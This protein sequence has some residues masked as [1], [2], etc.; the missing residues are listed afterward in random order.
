MF[1]VS[2]DEGRT[3]SEGVHVDPRFAIVRNGC[4]LVL[5]DG[6]I[7]GPAYIWISHHVKDAEQ[8]GAS[9][10]YGFAYFSDDEGLSWQRSEN[11]LVIR[12]NDVRY[13]FVD[14][15]FFRMTE[16]GRKHLTEFQR[17]DMFGEPTAA[18]L[19]DGRI[20]LLGRTRLGRPFK[21]SSNDRGLTS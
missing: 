15:K 10:C 17:L 8:D 11:E 21:S 1:H 7:L 13:D 5:S 16:E 18:E 14:N 2:R 6:R 4:G 20:V 19:D 3:W 9:L 12:E